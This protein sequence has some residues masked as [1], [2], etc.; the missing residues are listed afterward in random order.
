MFIGGRFS[1]IFCEVRLG[2]VVCGFL[3]QSSLG[4]GETGA[5]VRVVLWLPF[6]STFV[7]GRG[8]VGGGT[9]RIGCGEE[10]RGGAGG[11]T[12]RG[13]ATWVVLCGTGGG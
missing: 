10:R 8:G 12:G 7:S 3:L 9:L 4:C 1:A 5:T 6:G 13:A 2:I 11:G